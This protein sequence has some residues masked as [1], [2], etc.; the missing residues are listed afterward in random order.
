MPAILINKLIVPYTIYAILTVT[1]L[2]MMGHAEIIYP[3]LKYK[4]PSQTPKMLTIPSSTQAMPAAGS[5]TK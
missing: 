4:G 3:K 2:F 1:K 5:F